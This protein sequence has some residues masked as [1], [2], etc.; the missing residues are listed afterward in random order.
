MAVK[1]V[2]TLPRVEAPEKMT[3]EEFLAWCK[4]M[5]AEWINREIQMVFPAS[6]RHHQ[7]TMFLST[8]SLMPSLPLLANY[9]A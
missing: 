9:N 4:D 1:T 2:A 8:L 6:Q 5:R 3:L 7:V